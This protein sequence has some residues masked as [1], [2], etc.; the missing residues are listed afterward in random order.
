M[1]NIITEGKENIPRFNTTRAR[2]NHIKR[3]SSSEL[4][5][6]TPLRS[7]QQRVSQC[8]LKKNEM[9]METSTLSMENEEFSFKRLQEMA[10]SMEKVNKHMFKAP[11]QLLDHFPQEKTIEPKYIPCTP[12]RKNVPMRKAPHTICSGR[13]RSNSLAQAKGFNRSST[14]E[15]CPNH[16]LE[17]AKSTPK[18]RNDEPQV[19][20]STTEPQVYRST[21]VARKQWHLPHHQQ[22]PTQRTMSSR[23]TTKINSKIFQFNPRK[24]H[25][26]VQATDSSN[27]SVQNIANWLSDD[28]FEKKKQ[29]FIRK[30]DQITA[31][32][33]AFEHREVLEMQRHNKKESRVQRERQH[34]PEGKVSQRKDWLQSA[35]GENMEEDKEGNQT[36][37]VLDKMKIF[38]SSLNSKR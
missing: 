23:K 22:I 7:R 35:F 1:R 18:I 5:G 19:S 3:K 10:L 12:P 33:D 9:S 15:R 34:F 38:E 14:G 13:G 28:P 11:D 30:G 20:R 17:R 26:D 25:Q 36:S 31:K 21:N 16:S 29:I 8:K 4:N 32:A 27:A 24:V 37:S 2:T 6:H